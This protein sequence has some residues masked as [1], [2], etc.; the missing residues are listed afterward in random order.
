MMAV[1]S[2]A[3]IAPTGV[4]VEPII[5]IIRRL[6]DVLDQETKQLERN[7]VDSLSHFIDQKSRSLLELN[8]ALSEQPSPAD[9]P[10][11]DEELVRLRQAFDSNREMLGIH[12]AAVQEITEVIATAMR[13]AD[14]DG[15][16]STRIYAR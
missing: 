3:S 13:Q 2:D 10:G 1:H 7:E 15:T 11:L 16:Y 8:R 4:T 14:S 6:I 5:A 9:I 12:M